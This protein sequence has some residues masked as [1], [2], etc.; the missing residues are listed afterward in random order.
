MKKF[1]LVIVLLFLFTVFDTKIIGD[2]LYNTY[3][4]YFNTH[5]IKIISNPNILKQNEYHNKEISSFIK[6]THNYNVSDKDELINVYYTAINNGYENLTFYCDE[7][8]SECMDDI[9]N[10]DNEE[11][12]FS[13]I[14]QLVNVF[15][16]YDSIESVYSTD[17][18]VDIK[19]KRKY[20]KED[21]KKINNEINIIVNKLGINNYDN[22]LDKIKVFH[23]YIA[24]INTYDSIRANTGKSEYH[25]DNALGTLF[26]GK[27][28]CSGYTDT[29]SIF[30][31]KL[32]LT[33]VRVATDKHVWNA[34]YIDNE[35]KHIDLTWDDPLTSDGS[36]IINYDYYMLSTNELLSKND[37]EHTFN[38]DIYTF[39]KNN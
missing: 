19:I 32:N 7:Y 35:W 39:L 20:S 1:F 5:N 33:N 3:D 37:E 11:N 28:I 25:S 24:N 10:L 22:V 34:V 18:R 16:E 13:Y 29:L 38:T 6:E 9:N 17:H 4:K 27:S 26:E 12:N 2:S 14:N 8:Y 23:D 21:I 31:D 15:N 30:L 36:N